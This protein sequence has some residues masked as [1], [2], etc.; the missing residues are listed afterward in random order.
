MEPDGSLR[1][2]EASFPFLV[3]EIANTQ[4]E[5]SLD[6]KIHYWTYGSRQHLKFIVIFRIVPNKPTGYRVLVSVDKLGALAR[7]TAAN[8][9]GFIMEPAHIIVNEEIYPKTSAATFDITLA[10]VLPEKAS[11]SSAPVTISLRSF[12]GPGKRAVRA[13]EEKQ[14]NPRALSPRDPNEES[15]PSPAVSDH[16][17]TSS[18]FSSNNDIPADRSYKGK[19][20]DRGD[21]RGIGTRQ[22]SNRMS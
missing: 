4:T 7:P 17:S 8:P 18:S 14:N 22:S 20:V 3:A 6:K 1:L 21:S 10:D 11:G 13:L 9:H 19:A 15:V 5:P 16:E 12:G 2:A